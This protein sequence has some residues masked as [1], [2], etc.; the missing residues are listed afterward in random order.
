MAGA[1]HLDWIDYAERLIGGGAIDWASPAAVA[2]LINKAQALLPS[3]LVILPVARMLVAILS[4]AAEAASP[5]GAQPL[6]AL[7]ADEAVRAKLLETVAMMA[8][9]GLALGLPAPGLLAARAAERIGALSPDM[10]EDLVDDAALYVADF[11]RIFANARIEGVALTGTDSFPRLSAPIQK[12]AQSYGWK[13]SDDGLWDGVR[14]VHIAVDAEPEAVLA[15]VRALRLQG[16][17]V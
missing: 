11:L 9:P 8:V 10:D 1:L 3:D 17:T 7:L 6:R 16:E 2:G 12:V 15:Q 5:K 13:F 14:T 4:P